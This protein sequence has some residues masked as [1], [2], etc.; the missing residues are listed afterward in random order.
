M[1]A[2]AAGGGGTP[3]IPEAEEPQLQP[4]GDRSACASHMCA[5][6][7]QTDHRLAQDSTVDLDWH[8]CRTPD[9]A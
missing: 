1:A 2:E 9:A 8:G 5:A 4:P 6:C 7:I 3:V